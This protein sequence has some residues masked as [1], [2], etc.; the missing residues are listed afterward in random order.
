MLVVKIISMT[1]L[2]QFLDAQYS[3]DCNIPEIR[4]NHIIKQVT[5][6]LGFS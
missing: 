6:S 2:H 1:F 4:T 5:Q 3:P